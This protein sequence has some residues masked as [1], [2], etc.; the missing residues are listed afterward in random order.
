MGSVLN[1]LL[2]Y[3]TLAIAGIA[4]A[5]VFAVLLAKRTVLGKN[6]K[7]ILAALLI[8]L[9]VY[10]AFVIWIVVAAGGNQPGNVPTPVIPS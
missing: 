5:A 4:F 7:R 9:A 10:F 1:F 8:L 6:T 2:N 3:I